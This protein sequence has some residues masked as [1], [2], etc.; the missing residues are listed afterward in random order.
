MALIGLAIPEIAGLVL[1]LILSPR[2][3]AIDGQ[4]AIYITDCGR[5]RVLKFRPRQ[6]WP[7]PMAARPTPRPATPTPSTRAL[8]TPAPSTLEPLP[9]M[10]PT[11]R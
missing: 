5:H 8:S 3:I 1:S 6:P 7:A 2:G 10:T 11:D 9:S 4:G